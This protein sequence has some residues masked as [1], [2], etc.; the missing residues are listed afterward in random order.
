MPEYGERLPVGPQVGKGYVGY[1]N[2]G[3]L[4]AP[5][6]VLMKYMQDFETQ[7]LLF[8]GDTLSE[9]RDPNHKLSVILQRLFPSVPWSVIH[10]YSRTRFFIRLKF[11]NDN[12]GVIEKVYKKRYVNHVNKYN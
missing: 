7:F 3:R 4:T 11:L 1:I 10:F 5:K 2:Q 9:E 6:E 8:H 12:V